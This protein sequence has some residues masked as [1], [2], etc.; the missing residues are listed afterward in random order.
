MPSLLTAA[1]MT[2]NHNKSYLLLL[3]VVFH[4]HGLDEKEQVI[5]HREADKLGADTELTWVNSFV[6]EDIYSAFDRAKVFLKETIPEED[7]ESKLEI[8]TKV[9]RAN[10]EKGQISE[11]EATSMLRLAKDWKIERDLMAVI[12]GK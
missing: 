10:E 12:R 9:W 8:L 3:S 5:L 6:T 1:L 4:Y 7:R 11:M 2:A